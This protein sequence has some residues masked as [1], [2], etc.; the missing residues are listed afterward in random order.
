MNI[1]DLRNHFGVSWRKRQFQPD[2]AKKN[3]TRVEFNGHIVTFNPKIK[4]A[5]LAFIKRYFVK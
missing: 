5:I 1:L 2:F 3:F 4:V